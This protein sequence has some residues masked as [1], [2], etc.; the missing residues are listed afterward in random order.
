MRVHTVHEPELLGTAGTL[1]ANHSFF[2]GS[3]GL[4]IH[5]DNAMADDLRAYSLPTQP[6]PLSVC[7]RCSPSAL[8]NRAA[9]ASWSQMIQCVVT[10][11]YEKVADPPGTCA[12]GALY[13]FDGTF[14]DFLAGMIPKPTDFSTEVIPRLMGRIQT[15]HCEKPYLDIALPQPSLQPQS[16][17]PPYHE[18]TQS[19]FA[20]AAAEYLL[21]LQS[22][23][24]PDVLA[25]VETLAEELL[26]AWIEGRHV[27]ICGNG[28]SA[29][30]AMHMANDLHYGIGAC[31]PASNT[32]RHACGGLASQCGDHHLPGE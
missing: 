18:S 8:T 24:N 10:T 3:I 32:A 2:E 12:N 21:R 14:L 19:N 11:F 15:C 5:A 26:Q 25:A 16:L 1:L 30:N 9:A 13:V 27:Y 29:A 31:G 4:L 17:M 22:C 20:L 7:S 28:G 6:A 23:F